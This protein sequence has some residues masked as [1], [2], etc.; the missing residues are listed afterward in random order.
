M[1]NV[2][3][4]LPNLFLIY[5]FPKF[6]AKKDLERPFE[7]YK[8]QG[9]TNVISVCVFMIVLLANVFT[10]IQPVIDGQGFHDTIWMIAGPLGFGIVA[11]LIYQSYVNRTKKENK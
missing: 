3:M 6:K 5:A 7:V 1:A 2:S 8:N 4:T 10:I 11:A 9:W